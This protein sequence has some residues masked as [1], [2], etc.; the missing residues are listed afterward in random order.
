MKAD[1]KL[2]TMSKAAPN[3]SPLT[4]ELREFLD[5][6]VV[7][8]LLKQ[9]MSEKS[10]VQKSVARKPRCVAHFPRN[11]ESLGKKVRPW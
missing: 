1:S 11:A 4:P 6:V 8:I 10:E 5:T 2:V 3:D 9:Y 7:P